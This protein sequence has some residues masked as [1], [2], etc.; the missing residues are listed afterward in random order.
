[1]GGSAGAFAA[2]IHVRLA[3]ARISIVPE[4]AFLK[5][6]LLVH[7]KDLDQTISIIGNLIKECQTALRKK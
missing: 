6:H 3:N 7:E 4:A 2:L 1:M 5:E